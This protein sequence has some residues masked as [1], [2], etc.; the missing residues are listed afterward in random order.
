VGERVEKHPYRSKGERGKR[1]WDE[2][3]WSGNWEGGYHLKR[4]QIK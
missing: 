4:K 2:D 3:L 1:A